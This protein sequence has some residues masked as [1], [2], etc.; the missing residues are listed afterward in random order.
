MDIF[1][2]QEKASIHSLYLTIAYFLKEQEAEEYIS[3]RDPIFTNSEIRVVCK[4]V[5]Y[6]MDNIWEDNV[7]IEFLNIL[8]ESYARLENLRR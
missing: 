7:E 1:L 3:I 6:V 8:N 4:S 2:V 5:E